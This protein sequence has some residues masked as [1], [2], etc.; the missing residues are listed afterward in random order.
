M[1]LSLDKIIGGEF[2]G[3]GCGGREIR[4]REIFVGIVRIV[5]GVS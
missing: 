1:R 4:I 2:G 5:Y 3:F